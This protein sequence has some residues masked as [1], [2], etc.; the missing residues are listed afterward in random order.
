[1]AVARELGD[2]TDGAAASGAWIVRG[3]GN[4]RNLR[5]TGAGVPDVA[6][7]TGVAGS[8]PAPGGG[9]Y[10]HLDGGN[11]RFSFVQAS[12][13]T[14]PELPEANGLVRDWRRDG[15]TTRFAFSGYYK[16]FFRLANAGQCSVT[17]DGKP[18]RGVR[19][20]NTLRFDTP[21]V[22]DPIHVQQ[23]VEVRCG[24]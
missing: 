8:S 24:A 16:P 4:L 3:D 15:G 10:V 14:V 2:G 12:S 17:I 22:N 20:N 11:A 6:T 7:A 13:R 18:A 1:M 9:V 5:W 19:E 23:Q 21:A